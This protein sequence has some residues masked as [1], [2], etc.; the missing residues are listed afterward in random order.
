MLRF[1]VIALSML[2]FVVTAKPVEQYLPSNQQYLPDIAKPASILGFNIGERHVRHSE[3]LAYFENVAKQSTRV[4]LTSMGYT[5]QHRKQILVT[6]SSPENLANLDNILAKRDISMEAEADN[7]SKQ[8][9]VLW[10]GYGV[11]GDETS[12]VNS[13]LVL[14]YY[15][16]A[17]QSADVTNLLKNAVIVIEPAMNPDGLD[18]FVNWVDTYRTLTPNASADHIEH[19]EPW[20]SGRTNHYWFDLNRDWLLISQ[21]ETANRLPFF[22][23]YQPN[24]VSDYHEM[25]AHKTYFFQPGVSNRTNPLISQENKAFT[26]AL[27]GFHAQTLDKNKRLY[28]SGEGYDDFFF[29]KGSTYPDINGGIGILFEQ[30]SSTGFQLNT[31]N[32]LLTLTKGIENNIFTA[33]STFKGVLA[34]KKKLHEY[35]AGFFEQALTLASEQN[36]DGYLIHEAHDAYRLDAFLNKLNQHQI[37]V[38]PLEKDFEYEDKLYRKNSSYYVPLVQ[39]KYH[40]IR[41]LFDK[42]T[43]FNDTQFYDISSWT[44]PLAM[45]IE[46]HEIETSYR[47]KIAKQAWQPTASIWQQP[48]TENNYAYAFSWEHFL[49]PKLLN[50]LLNSGL[51]VRV[52]KANFSAQV[53]G[54]EQPFERGSIVIPH[55][56]QTQK[57]WQ[58]ALFK[59]AQEANITLH[60]ITS[61][62]TAVGSDLGSFSML[63]ISPINVL[64]VGGDGVSSYEA[65]E[66]LYYLDK[67]LNIPVTI[68][69]Q[70][71]IHKVDLATYTHVLLVD[72][73]YSDLALSIEKIKQFVSQGGVIFGQKKGAQWLADNGLLKARLTRENALTKLF[74]V[75][76]LTYQDR[77]TL[78]A[79]QRIPGTIFEGVLDLSHPLTFGYNNRHLPLFRNHSA[80]IAKTYLAFSEVIK[81]E[82]RPLLSGY[83][84]PQ[85]LEYVAQ[86]PTLVAHNVDQGRVIAS[87]DN[88]LFRGFWLGSAKLLANSLFFAHTFD[89]PDK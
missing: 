10:F 9:V 74:Q 31:V 39:P 22:N 37:K 76:N 33:L 24:I 14:A 1:I 30:A 53:N 45:N 72:G 28:F 69:E 84:S 56:L 82:R 85:L 15:L 88:L 83:V 18:R 40:L 54:A 49:A 62:F 38:Y 51:K 13:A 66:V 3:V 70:R 52:A 17:S 16:A 61:G 87:M 2:V 32:G 78:N 57:N 34:N 60:N 86:T 64:L 36:F 43:Q 59:A 23:R 50:S 27:A 11:H 48:L 79:K 6:V 89:V 41:T 20:P 46:Y 80:I 29:G 44:M 47:L 19:H 68:V 77:S 8:P 12:G 35:R 65:G 75:A 81:Y 4:K 42:T 25:S 58:Q 71:R 63:P 26:Q 73:N 5:P 21:Q 7:L 55:A 67:Q